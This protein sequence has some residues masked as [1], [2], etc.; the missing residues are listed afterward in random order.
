MGWAK[1][2]RIEKGLFVPLLIYSVRLSVE[3]VD[4]LV[5]SVSVS[6]YFSV[7]LTGWSISD[8]VD[9]CRCVP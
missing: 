3:I 1:R 8:L 2:V 5:L 9:P 7:A 6:L 4:T